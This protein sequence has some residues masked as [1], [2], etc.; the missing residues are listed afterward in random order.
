MLN[1]GS[2]EEDV[3]QSEGGMSV[4]GQGRPVPEKRWGMVLVR[5]EAE[6]VEEEEE[7]E[8]AFDPLEGKVD[9]RLE[10]EEEEESRSSSSS[11]FGSYILSLRRGDWLYRLNLEGEGL[12]VGFLD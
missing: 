8:E 1:E 11:S 9:S 3:C 12:I 5:E 6:V 4:S 10:E 7:V 2:K